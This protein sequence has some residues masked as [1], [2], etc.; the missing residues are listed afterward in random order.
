MSKK[1]K[2]NRWM[3]IGMT[4]VLAGFAIALAGS[5]TVAVYSEMKQRGVVGR[6]AATEAPATGS[7][8]S[9]EEEEEM[10]EADIIRYSCVISEG[11][12]DENSGSAF[13][14]EFY[15]KKGTYK[16]FLVAGDSKSELHRGT[17]KEGKESIEA[18]DKDGKKNTLFRDGDYL[19]S[20]NAM[21]DDEVPDKKTFDKTFV[22]EVQDKS[23][24][25]I[26]FKKDGTY[27]QRITRYSAGLTG[28][29]TN[30]ITTGTYERKGN[31][32]MRKQDGR[33]EVMPYYIYQGKLCTGY[34]KKEEKK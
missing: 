3:N 28:D 22:N 24:V 8:V 12:G 31:M 32:I 29:D 27:S 30:D 26:E 34:Y 1:G 33:E 7:A 25:E 2:K 13:Y 20:E 10:D 5:V 17:Y 6:P 14:M 4:V 21:F 11:N 16:E 9:A 23:R 15:Y 18:V 19:V